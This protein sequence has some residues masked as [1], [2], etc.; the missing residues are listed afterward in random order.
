MHRTGMHESELNSY[1]NYV[2][3][4]TYLLDVGIKSNNFWCNL[5]HDCWNTR[6]TINYEITGIPL[7]KIIYKKKEFCWLSYENNCSIFSTQ[8]ISF[9]IR[10]WKNLFKV[11]SFIYQMMHNIP[12]ACMFYG[13][14]WINLFVALVKKNHDT[15]I[16][17]S[18]YC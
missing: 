18:S 3:I 13:I 5:F 14:M 10:Y 6:R 17:K 9:A 1:K 8:D 16:F 4:L 11:L 2:Y 7:A 12:L 15:K